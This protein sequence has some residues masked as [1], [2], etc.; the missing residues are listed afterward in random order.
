MTGEALQQKTNESEDS[1]LKRLELYYAQAA[2]LLAHYGKAHA[3]VRV[4][5]TQHPLFVFKAIKD[6]VQNLSLDRVIE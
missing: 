4:D 2:P 3:L 5:A 1:V 6:G